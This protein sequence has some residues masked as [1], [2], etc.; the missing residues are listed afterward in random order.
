MS[1]ITFQGKQRVTVTAVDGS[2]LYYILS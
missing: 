2:S 1:W